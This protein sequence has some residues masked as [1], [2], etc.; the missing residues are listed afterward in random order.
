MLAI[1]KRQRHGAGPLVHGA[2]FVD[3]GRHEIQASIE[4]VEK[5]VERWS[6][7][8]RCAIRHHDHSKLTRT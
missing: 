6:N 8:D 7:F 3:C 4:V 2:M 1:E 5:N